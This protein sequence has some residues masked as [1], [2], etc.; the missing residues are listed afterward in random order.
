MR[1]RTTPGQSFGEQFNL[2]DADFKPLP[3]DA[4]QHISPEEAKRIAVLNGFADAKSCLQAGYA[5]AAE[6]IW[7]PAG[8]SNPSPACHILWLMKDH[9][10]NVGYGGLAVKA[11]YPI[12][13]VLHL[14]TVICTATSQAVQSAQSMMAKKFGLP[15]EAVSNAFVGIDREAN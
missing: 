7:P 1:N 3:R 9:H 6:V 14:Y 2:A 10:E 5:G 4:W 8:P 11:G 13:Q 12:G 15:D